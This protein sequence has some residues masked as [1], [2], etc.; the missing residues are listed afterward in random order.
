MSK[1][2][3]QS[4]RLECLRSHRNAVI[5]FYAKTYNGIR[6]LINDQKKRI[7]A[8]GN[9]EPKVAYPQDRETCFADC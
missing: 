1:Q 4:I 6:Q 7:R 2:P 5:S 9:K 3:E 8:N